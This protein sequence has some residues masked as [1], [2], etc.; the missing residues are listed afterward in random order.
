MNSHGAKNTKNNSLSIVIGAIRSVDKDD[1]EIITPWIHQRILQKFISEFY[2]WFSKMMH[3]ML[4]HGIFC[5]WRVLANSWYKF[6]ALVLVSIVY[7]KHLCS[8]F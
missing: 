7:Q 2:V 8:I 6:V 5:H 4:S 1:I 3:E